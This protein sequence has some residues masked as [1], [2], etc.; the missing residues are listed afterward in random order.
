VTPYVA[1]QIEILRRIAQRGLRAAQDHND[2]RYIDLFQ[3]LLDE[4][5]RTKEAP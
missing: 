5:Q 2:T 3:H 4:I 1:E